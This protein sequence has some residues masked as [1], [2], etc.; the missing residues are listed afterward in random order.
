MC[1][2]LMGRLAPR[3]LISIEPNLL[4]PKKAG[5]ERQ[6]YLRDYLIVCATL[7]RKLESRPVRRFIGEKGRRLLTSKGA[8]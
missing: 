1:G 7:S 8:I 2:I 5:N 4:S 3:I 6:A